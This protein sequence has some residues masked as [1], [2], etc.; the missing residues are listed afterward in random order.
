MSI[1][2]EITRL[3][4]AKSDLATAIANKGV[5]VPSSTLIDGYASLVD[6][7]DYLPEAD[8]SD[9]NFYDYDGKILYSYTASE[10][11]ALTALPANPSHPGLTAQGWNYT[12]AQVQAEVTAQGQCDVGQMYITDDG[13]TR[14]YVRMEEGRLSPYL[15]IAPNGTVVVDWGDGSDTE[16]LTGTSLSTVVY[17]S[18]HVY[19]SAGDYVITLT[20]TSGQFCILGTTYGTYL[21]RKGDDT[22]KT[23]NSVYTASIRKIEIGSSVA[24]GNFAFSRCENL[25]SVTM[26]SDIPTISYYLNPYVFSRCSSL[27]YAT[28][29]DGITSIGGGLVENCTSLALLSVPSG[30]KQFGSYTFNNAAALRRMIMPSTFTTI[31]EYTFNACRSISKLTIPANVESIAKY[32]FNG[33]YGLGE[34]HFLGTTPPTLADSSVFTNLPTDCK[35]YVPS[36]SLSAYTSASNYPDSTTYTYIEE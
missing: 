19:E 24:L 35:I 6:A 28:I 14:I 9:V 32:A 7:I 12:L 3:Q 33:D 8:L 30:C 11:L 17:T 4:T 27:K 2:T 26:S 25:E 13:K 36:G 1:A 5:T 21:L 16:T 10:A 23:E 29:P 22:L 34:V 18:Q 20:V 31:G 15:G